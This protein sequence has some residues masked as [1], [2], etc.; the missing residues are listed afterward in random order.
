MHDVPRLQCGQRL[1]ELEEEHLDMGRSQGLGGV[2]EVGQIRL[3][4]L[5][6]KKQ[7]FKR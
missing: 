3:L 4:V 1:Q 7:L 5:Q 2:E 6:H